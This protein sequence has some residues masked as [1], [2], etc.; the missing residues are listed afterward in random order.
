MEKIKVTP[1]QATQFM[2]LGHT[3]ECYVLMDSA[4]PVE[5]RSRRK[6]SKQILPDTQLGL[7]VNGKGP[8]KGVYGEAWEYLVKKLWNGDPTITFSRDRISKALKEGK[9][10]VDG[11]YY[12]YLVNKCQCLRIIE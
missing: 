8:G 5:R 10:T 11:A 3:V 12:A 6:P 1:K 7:T 2:A 9:F 4:P